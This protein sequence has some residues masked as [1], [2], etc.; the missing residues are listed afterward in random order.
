M[1]GSEANAGSV[2]KSRSKQRAAVV[3]VVCN[4]T[5]VIAKVGIGLTSG[6]VS[7]LS[8]GLHSAT[9]LIGSI[10]AF[11][12]VRVADTPPDEE[13][14]YGH[15]K[16]EYLAGLFESLLIFL[17]ACGI[18]F[19]STARLLHP[20]ERHLE[21]SL[22]LWV[23]GAS[24]IVSFSL[25]HFLKVVAKKT[26]SL[27]IEAEASHVA[28]DVLTSAGVFTGLILA[29]ITHLA[30]IDPVAGILISLLILRAAIKMSKTSYS[31]LIDIRLPLEEVASIKKLLDA[32]ERVLG[33][34][35]LR[36][37]KSG[38]FRH[39]DVHVQVD[40]D[41]SLVEAH[42]IAEQIEDSI[43]EVLPETHISIHL[44]PYRAEMS[45]QRD[46]HGLRPEELN[47]KLNSLS[48][49]SQKLSNSNSPPLD[50]F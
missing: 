44:E 29:K 31:H 20:N 22:A 12:S 4:L 6:A 3:S 46:V 26:D 43:R 2:K 28:T 30:W 33:Y 21:L 23:M 11:Y 36:T 19:S 40:D 8:E 9:D 10:I 39:A 45:H 25:S 27:A 13:H 48:H 38:S 49:S 47:P 41:L 16:I 15:G 5:L 50:K 7:V 34:H 1:P 24:S 18:I 32:D 35:K 42:E 37:R 14:P 17:A